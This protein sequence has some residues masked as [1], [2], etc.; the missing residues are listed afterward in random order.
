MHASLLHMWEV[1]LEAWAILIEWRLHYQTLKLSLFFFLLLIRRFSF[2][3]QTIDFKSVYKN[4]SNLPEQWEA[5]KND[6]GELCVHW[7]TY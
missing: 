7:T 5:F 6:K 3:G 1:I 4:R 2:L